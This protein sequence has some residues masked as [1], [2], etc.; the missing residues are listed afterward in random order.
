MIKKRFVLFLLLPCLLTA[1]R[2]KSPTATDL[3]AKLLTLPDTPAVSIYFSGAAAEEDGYLPEDAEDILYNGQ[4]PVALAE[5][6]A[7]A[8]GRGDQ[9]FEYHLYYALDAEKADQIETIL[10]HRQ[11]LLLKQGNYLYDPENPAARATVWRRGKWVGL[12]VTE[13]NDAA[14]SL[15]KRQF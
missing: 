5:D 13:S 3:L 1:C 7:I 14:K 15:L 9:I 4:S 12:L 2:Q 10:R 8:L 11:V 6:F